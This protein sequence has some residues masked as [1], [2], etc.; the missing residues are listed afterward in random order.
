M[1]SGR[2]IVLGIVQLEL[3]DA[4]GAE[5]CEQAAVVDLLI[6]GGILT[7]ERVA[8]SSR[9]VGRQSDNEAASGGARCGDAAEEQEE[10]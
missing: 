1:V 2:I 7:S 5:R 4:D 10:R 8:K 6:L 3:R 9:P